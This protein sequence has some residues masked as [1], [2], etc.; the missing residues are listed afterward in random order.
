PEQLPLPAKLVAIFKGVKPNLPRA[1]DLKNAVVEALGRSNSPD[2]QTALREI[3]D[4]DAAQK[5]PVAKALSRFPVA[6][7]Y[8]YLMLGLAADQGGTGADLLEAL[9][10]NP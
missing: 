1:I 2:A 3:A 9:K 5:L 4:T 7:N 8:P 10:K 6:E